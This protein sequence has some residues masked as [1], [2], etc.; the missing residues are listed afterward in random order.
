VAGLIRASQSFACGR[1]HVGNLF[2]YEETIP[3]GQLN[4][5]AGFGAYGQT[6]DNHLCLN[7]GCGNYASIASVTTT[8]LHLQHIC[9][10]G[11]F[12]T[13]MKVTG[14][15]FNQGPALLNNPCSK[16][17]HPIDHTGWPTL[18]QRRNCG[19]L[20]RL[21]Q[22]MRTSG[23]EPLRTPNLTTTNTNYNTA[24]IYGPDP[25]GGLSRSQPDL[26]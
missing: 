26:S 4:P 18:K 12:G 9:V 16:A 11:V 23:Y 8:L 1:R 19:S 10:Y 22:R 20:L 14:W 21:L 25:L 5:A 24:V 17:N 2:D 3:R 13:H 15:L 6:P 7:M